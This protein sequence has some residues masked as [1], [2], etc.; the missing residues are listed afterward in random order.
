ML[1]AGELAVVAVTGLAG[2]AINALVGSATLFTFPVLLALG[3]PPVTANV[4]NT[5]G[6]VP[7]SLAGAWGYRR[8]LA[9]QRHRVLVLAAVSAVG[10]LL[11]AV[12]LLALPSGVF[13]AVVPLLVLVA[14]LLV[15]AQPLV[16]R[17]AT[18]GAASLTGPDRAVG[19][20]LLVGVTLSGVYGGYFGAAQGVLL[21]ALLGLLLDP[22]LQRVNGIKNVLAATVNGV[23][24]VLFVLAG[25][26]RWDVAVVLA[27]G[28]GVGGLL[29]ARLGRGLP[30]AALRGLIVAVGV[31][32]LVSL[33]L[34]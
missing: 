10:G 31:A 34:T 1:S 7:G 13:D 25:D 29:G 4:T 8:E 16:A 27:A 2:G 12:L 3:L 22:D 20:L 24:A 19:P 17:R 23:A 21:L 6:L 5:L 30:R 26:I 28:A 9:G 32:A 11:G 33:L 14:V 18:A 15:A